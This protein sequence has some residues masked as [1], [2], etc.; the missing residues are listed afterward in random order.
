MRCVCACMHACVC[1]CVHVNSAVMAR[2]TCLYVWCTMCIIYACVIVHQRGCVDYT[3]MYIAMH[4]GTGQ[5]V[6]LY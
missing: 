4:D 3:V 2:N 5:C 1:A 6:Y